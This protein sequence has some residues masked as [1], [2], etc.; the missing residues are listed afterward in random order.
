MKAKIKR[1]LVDAA[2]GYVNTYLQEY[3]FNSIVH[4]NG[5]IIILLDDEHY[6]IVKVGITES[7]MVIRGFK[8]HDIIYGINTRAIYIKTDFGI[9]H[10]S[11]DNAKLLIEK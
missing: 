10:L 7:F 6:K 3:G 11:K 4:E 5:K 2:T 1:S 9:E 8:K